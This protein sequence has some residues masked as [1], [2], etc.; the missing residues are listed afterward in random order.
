M[1]GL[2]ATGTIGDDTAVFDTS[3][4]SAAAYRQ[5]FEGPLRDSWHRDLLASA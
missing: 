3:V 1:P 2:A 5:R 4:T